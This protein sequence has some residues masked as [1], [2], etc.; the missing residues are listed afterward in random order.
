M[1]MI[2]PY[3]PVILPTFMF[4]LPDGGN[5]LMSDVV[6]PTNGYRLGQEIRL[7]QRAIGVKE[8]GLIGPET[9]EAIRRLAVS[10]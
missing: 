7:I 3:E 8:D 10:Q 6:E 4:K 1:P 2:D 9:R 5:G